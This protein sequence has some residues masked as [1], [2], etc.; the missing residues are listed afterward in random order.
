MIKNRLYPLIEKYINEYLFGF[1]KEQ[2]EIG[3]T[4][5]ILHLD[6]L[7]LRP[8]AI[9][10]KL[11]EKNLPVWLKAGL[12]SKIQVGCSLM[13]FIG[14]KP[15]D[16]LIEGV[17]VLLTP[18]YR[19]IIMNVNSFLS[20]TEDR[21]AEPYDQADNNSRDIFTQK[22]NV[23]D[24]SIFK[25]PF[26]LEIFKDKTKISNII[27]KLFHKC[28]KFYYM[29][30]YAVNL[31][32]K[33]IHIR[34]EDDQLI[35]FIGDIAVG[36]KLSKFTLNLSSEGI[37]KRDLFKLEKMDVYW[38]LKP[39]IL[40][41]SEVLTTS[42]Q[43]ISKENNY[44]EG[45]LK[46][47]EKYY[48]RLKAINFSNFQYAPNTCF[49]IQNF[50]CN[51]KIGTQS[52]D[53]GDMDIFSKKEKTY[54]L[55]LQFASSE[56]NIN[57]Y[58]E[59]AT[60]G[61]NFQNFFK[62]FVIIKEVESFKPMR[63]PM[64]KNDPV[65]SK[66]L[67]YLRSKGNTS[68]LSKDFSYKKKMYVRDWLFYFFWCKKC[69]TSMEGKSTNPLRLE[70]S[71]FFNVVYGNLSEDPK[72]NNIQDKKK[73]TVSNSVYDSQQFGTVKSKQTPDNPNPDNVNINLI[74][75]LLIKGVNVNLHS[76]YANQKTSGKD[77]FIA[78][79]FSGGEIKINLDKK[80]FDLNI[81]FKGFN[82]GPNE[83]IEGERVTISNNKKKPIQNTFIPNN[84]MNMMFK[85]MQGMPMMGD[86]L[87]PLMN[88][89][90]GKEPQIANNYS[91]MTV[92]Q[93]PKENEDT[94]TKLL[95]RD[96]SYS[97]KMKLLN[98]TLL[99]VGDKKNNPSVINTPNIPKKSNNFNSYSK[100]SRPIKE[101]IPQGN[102]PI[103][104]KEKEGN[105]KGNINIESTLSVRNNF[106]T[107]YL[108][109]VKESAVKQITSRVDMEKQNK[110]ISIS[111]K[112]SEYN[113]EKSQN[114][115]MIS[116][117]R[118]DSSQ[119][120]N[121]GNSENEKKII[122]LNLFEIYSKENS[123]SI[124]LKFTKS[125]SQNLTDSIYF[126]LGTLR[127]NLFSE[128]VSFVLSIIGDYKAIFNKPQK[129]NATNKLTSGLKMQRQLINMKKYIYNYLLKLPE[130]KK[131]WQIKEYINYLK[132]EIEVADSILRNKGNFEINYILSMFANG[133]QMEFNYNNFECVY[134]QKESK[135]KSTHKILGKCLIP[136]IDLLMKITISSI[137]LRFFDLEFEIN[138]LENSKILMTNIL[139]IMEE[140]LKTATIF[141]QPCFKELREEFDKLY[142]NKEKELNVKESEEFGTPKMISGNIN[143]YSYEVS[144]P[145]PGNQ[146]KYPLYENHSD[147]DINEDDEDN[148][149]IKY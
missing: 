11:D 136:Q 81:N 50:N 68:K 135:G 131:D 84:P 25:Q 117:N 40:I 70:F 120:T 74:V 53:S 49:I 114:Q 87:M 36:F 88:Y 37:Q 132:K 143:R 80:Q 101:D 111:Q 125:N 56:L 51:G 104:I 85:P 141:I 128:Y 89:R 59:L 21:I 66:M 72:F 3:I 91:A 140:K 67:N 24:S 83:L 75:Q 31:T 103:Q 94:I 149:N 144:K 106:F 146:P 34:F 13:N 27:N 32:V 133:I 73:D 19:W 115:S 82:L 77:S 96:P 127:L 63:K 102:Q 99:N 98:Q 79:K 22:V 55:Y 54:K 7:N 16:V 112:I 138:D 118:K 109:S 110:D 139:K 116:A 2:L 61:H 44:S 71:R 62:E 43:F 142:D 26:I 97:S 121:K 48:Q 90:K 1:S 145:Q 28:F 15:L 14:E 35:N 134:Y 38:E 69:T 123:P 60:I 124:Q 58:P 93:P 76:P 147:E 8:D 46:L 100:T 64:D 78:L 119:N 137:F 52:M 107:N 9:N 17:D 4:K 5:G 95:K 108:S 23:F 39:K 18:S 113:R 30:N 33:D 86:G 126:N 129:K 20:E 122:P 41:S 42:L 57:V 148:Y 47:D 12:I 105:T 130:D 92:R 65:I 29:K 6:K 45:T 10:T